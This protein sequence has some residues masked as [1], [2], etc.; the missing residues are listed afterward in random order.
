[1]VK[2]ISQ[3][4]SRWGRIRSTEG[5]PLSL[6]LTWAEQDRHVRR[7]TWN[8]QEIVTGYTTRAQGEHNKYH[9]NYTSRKPKVRISE[10]QLSLPRTVYYGQGGPHYSSVQPQLYQN[11]QHS[12]MSFHPHSSIEAGWERWLVFPRRLLPDTSPGSVSVGYVVQAP[13]QD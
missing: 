4:L 3:H 11:L 13:I 6:R 1:M 5:E 12:L 10:E 2:Q 9:I 8:A 7:K